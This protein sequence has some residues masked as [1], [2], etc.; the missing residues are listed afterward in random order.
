MCGLLC[1]H[2]NAGQDGFRSTSSK[3]WGGLKQL[4]LVWKA[5]AQNTR[6][7]LEQFQ[8]DDG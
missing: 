2:V 8:G 4:L 3:Q 5:D 6:V 1:P 7:D